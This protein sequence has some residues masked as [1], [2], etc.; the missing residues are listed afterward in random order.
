MKHN[1]RSHLIGHA[2]C[3]FVGS[4]SCSSSSSSGRS[5]CGGWWLVGVYLDPEG[6]V[7]SMTKKGSHALT[8]LYVQ[9]NRFLMFYYYYYLPRAL[10]PNCKIIVCV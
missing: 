8:S 4:V 9:R 1:V 7:L 3:L 10:K 2:L 5:C 6:L